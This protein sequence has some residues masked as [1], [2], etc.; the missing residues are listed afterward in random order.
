[1][2]LP[3]YAMIS[4]AN[5][6]NIALESPQDIQMKQ[7]QIDQMAIGNK[8]NQLKLNQANRM[9][10]SDAAL[11]D[12]LNKN[13]SVDPSTGKLVI[14]HAQVAA[15]LANSGHVDRAYQYTIDQQKA[16]YDKHKDQFAVIASA[17]QG[18][19]A[20]PPE[21]RPQAYQQALAQL[22]QS[23]ID[24]TG[25]PQQYDENYLNGVINANIDAKTHFEAPVK[26][27]NAQTAAAREN[28]YSRNVDSLSAR[29]EAQNQHLTVGDAGNMTPEDHDFYGE[30]YAKGDVSVLRNMS[31]ADAAATRQA[32]RKYL[33]GG[34]GDADTAITDR[35]DNAAAAKAIKDFSTG[36]QGNSVR[37]FNTALEHINSLESL[38]PALD[39]GDVQI[40][41]KAKNAY[42]AATGKTAPTNFD[43]T[44]KIVADEIVKAIIGGATALGDRDEAAK[45][46]NSQNSPAQLQ[47]V[48]DHYKELMG[49]QLKGLEEQ[50][51][52][53]TGRNDFAQKYLTGHARK[54]RDE[55]YAKTDSSSPSTASLH[56]ADIQALID[57]ARSK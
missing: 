19:L 52:S 54:V 12:S 4:N 51:K 28:D 43:A 10:D 53:S 15:D 47:G 21:V 40:I 50:Y 31:K 13:A 41:N 29:R 36:K 44:K 37:S 38:I 23:G 20:Q 57:A 18:V 45:V 56:P 46:I 2:Q 1:M 6:Q 33:Q 9:A 22:K 16:A 8:G 17:A 32:A 25:A 34:G 14:N 30:Q 48:I 27:L 49:G 5:P 35:Q 3:D 7:Q 11:R 26:E 42:A 55:L 24:T 39:N